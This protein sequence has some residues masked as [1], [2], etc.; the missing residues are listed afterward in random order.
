MTEEKELQIT[1]VLQEGVQEEKTDFVKENL[2]QNQTEKAEALAVNS[3]IKEMFH[4]RNVDVRSYSP[5]ALAHIGDGIFELVIRSMVIGKGNTQANRLHQH[6]SHIVKAASQAA[7]I[8]AI[9]GDLTEEELAVYH[10]GRN[11]KSPTTAKNASVADYR[12]AT[13]FEALM[14]YL[15][16]Q[17]NIP[18]IVELTKLGLEKAHILH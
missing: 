4:L 11:A 8:E 5:L 17:D 6:T 3:Y 16:L 15:Y 2:Q 13:G 14:G 1:E 18:R 10:R 12:K 9:E 7:M